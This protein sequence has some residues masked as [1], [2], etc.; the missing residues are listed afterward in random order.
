MV[1]RTGPRYLVPINVTEFVPV[2][3]RRSQGGTASPSLLLFMSALLPPDCCC[4]LGHGVPQLQQL[5]S[6]L[7]R[8]AIASLSI[9]A[10]DRPPIR[11]RMS[12]L[13]Y[14]GIS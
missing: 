12:G 11:S 1:T 9:F 5:P 7:S 10:M 2:T 14:P 8:F 4:D 13:R 3:A 6:C